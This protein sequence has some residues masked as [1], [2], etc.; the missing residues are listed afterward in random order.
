MPSLTPCT[1]IRQEID[2]MRPNDI[3]QAYHMERAIAAGQGISRYPCGCELCHGFKIQSLKVVE[4]HYRKYGRDRNLLQPL[5][6]S[7]SIHMS[8]QC[9]LILA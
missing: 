7:N 4:T 8:C 9:H 6:V 5:L 3:G 2:E 1:S